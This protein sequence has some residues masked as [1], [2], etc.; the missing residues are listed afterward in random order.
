MTF[1]KNL[2]PTCCCVCRGERVG[3]LLEVDARRY[4]RC[5][6]CEAT[7]VQPD[8]LPSAE[9]ELAEYLRHQNDPEDPGYRRFLSRVAEPLLERLEP[10]SR[11]LD[12][13]CGPGPALAAM[14]EEAGHKVARYDVFFQPDPA[15]LATTHDFITCT[16]TAEHFHR[17]ADELDRLEGLLRP[18]G[19]LAV[20]TCFQTDDARFATWHYRRDPTHVVFY[21]ESTWRHLAAARGW[22]CEIPRKDVALLR[23]PL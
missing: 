10:G 1:L 6:D 4:W 16:E 3:L 14:L 22:T 9:E 23:K 8:Q 13:G 7:F 20:M 15:P 21:R 2:S 11:G 12:Y 5:A 18:G 19:W 17:P